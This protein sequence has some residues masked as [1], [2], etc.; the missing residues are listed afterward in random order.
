MLYSDL[1][2]DRISYWPAFSQSTQ[3]I[4]PQ[5]TFGFIMQKKTQTNGDVV[6]SAMWSYLVP[7]KYAPTYKPRLSPAVRDQCIIY[8][9]DD[10][11]YI[12]DNFLN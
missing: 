2:Y 5:Q 11:D 9:A 3:F 12:Y 7:N 4:L 10:P 8:A 6:Q 1:F